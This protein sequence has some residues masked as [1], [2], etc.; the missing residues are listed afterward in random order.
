ME[1]VN[2]LRN[3]VLPVT[4]TNYLIDILKMATSSTV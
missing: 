4:T 2:V 3:S 1:V